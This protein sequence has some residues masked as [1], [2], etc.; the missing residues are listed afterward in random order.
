MKKIVVILLSVLS[1]TAFA[2]NTKKVAILET[3]DRE[4]NVLYG[5]LL[6]LRSNLTY[7]IASTPGYDDYSRADT[8][9]FGCSGGSYTPSNP[10]TG[11]GSTQQGDDKITLKVGNVS[12]NMIK[13]EAGSFIMG[14][15]NEG[16]GECKNKETPCHNVTITRDY[17]IGEYE[18]TQKLYKAVMGDNP[19]H[20]KADDNPVEMVSWNDAQKF[21]TELSRITGRNFTLPTEAEW[22]YA[23]RGGKKSTGTIYSGGSNL[24]I[25]S[26]SGYNSDDQ[27]H[28]VGRLRPNELGI[29]DMSGNVNEWCLDW[30]AVYS[31]D[32]QT[33]PVGPDTGLYRVLRGGGSGDYLGHS[34]M[35]RGNDGP[36][37]RSYFRGFRIVMH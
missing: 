1:L 32:N 26:W 31:S 4:G 24:V 9:L 10:I 37:Y 13:V 30:Y 33:D 29:Y 14:C 11:G 22:E 12:F 27:T 16:N 36:Q 28:P 17:Y 20:F 5:G 8:K 18:V 3:V 34:V 7:A 2:Q 21:C 6:Q 23:A 25:V 35:S 15:T 19:S